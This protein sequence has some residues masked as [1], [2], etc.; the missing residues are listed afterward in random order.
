M[1]TIET[2]YEPN[3][4]QCENLTYGGMVT[5]VAQTDTHHAFRVVK[6]GR[7]FDIVSMRGTDQDEFLL[8]RAADDVRIA[9]QA[10]RWIRLAL[11]HLEDQGAW[12]RRVRDAYDSAEYHMRRRDFSV[13]LR[14][15]PDD[16]LALAK[17]MIDARRL[18]PIEPRSTIS[19]DAV[20]MAG[21]R[22]KHR[23]ETNFE[24]GVY[25]RRES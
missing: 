6:P 23:I 18:V 7:Q 16:A 12:V 13:T 5:L 8:T 20:A 14:L 24:K 21:Y 15:R 9:G 11:P 25:K 19:W 2:A 3:L 1:P 22:L 4:Y 10:N 17:A